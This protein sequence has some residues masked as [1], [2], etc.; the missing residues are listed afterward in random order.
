MCSGSSI[1]RF[2][3]HNTSPS[4]A[5]DTTDR[6]LLWERTRSSGSGPSSMQRMLSSSKPCH[7][8]LRT[9]S[10][11]LLADRTASPQYLAG[12]LARDNCRLLIL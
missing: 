6:S 8:A 2:G 3:G 11:H 9:F 5:A 4:V 10:V 12:D 7:E 1:Q